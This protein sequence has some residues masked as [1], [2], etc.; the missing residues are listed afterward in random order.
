MPTENGAVSECLLTVRFFHSRI[1]L[2][3]SFLKINKEILPP[4]VV[5]GVTEEVQSSVHSTSLQFWRNFLHIFAQHKTEN[6]FTT[7]RRNVTTWNFAGIL[8]G[9]SS[10]KIMC[11]FTLLSAFPHHERQVSHTAQMSIWVYAYAFM[12]NVHTGVL[13]LLSGWFFHRWC[14][15]LW[16][17]CCLFYFFDSRCSRLVKGLISL[18]KTQPS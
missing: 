16:A 10:S 4:H 6:V 15:K 18:F 11:L 3:R 5:P 13:F 9:T 14:N 1:C 7:T 17:T 12:R 8:F 2:R